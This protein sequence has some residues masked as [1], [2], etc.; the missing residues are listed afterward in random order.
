SGPS[1]GQVVNLGPMLK[2]YYALRGWDLKTGYPTRK[3]LVEL[4]LEYVAND[5]QKLGKL[6]E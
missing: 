4:G 3:K 6:A 5:L 2:E 1:K